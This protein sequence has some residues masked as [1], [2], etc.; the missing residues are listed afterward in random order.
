MD[1]FTMRRMVFYLI[2][3]YFMMRV[4][5]L[6][7]ITPND[8][9]FLL[10]M[11]V[12]IE[13]AFTLYID[14]YKDQVF[15]NREKALAYI[16]PLSGTNVFERIKPFPLSKHP[17]RDVS[18]STWMIDDDRTKVIVLKM[19]RYR[20]PKVV[21]IDQS[22]VEKASAAKIRYSNAAVQSAEVIWRNYQ[23]GAAYDLFK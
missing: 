7:D 19:R 23:E 14:L 18:R 3:V 5:W 16:E 20:K 1:R 10:L 17:F 8:V 9:V 13:T 2:S 21:F 22:L 12:I 11:A 4:F 15:K 6:I